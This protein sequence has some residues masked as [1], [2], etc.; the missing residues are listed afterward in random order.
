MIIF[1]KIDILKKSID[2]LASFVGS[3]IAILVL[4]FLH[5]EILGEMDVIAIAASF[6]A[7]STLLYGNPESSHAQPWNCIVGNI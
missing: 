3:F 7:Q 2:H 4:A 6:G 5:Y 1:L